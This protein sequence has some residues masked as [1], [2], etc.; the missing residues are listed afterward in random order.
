L[1]RISK[2]E[3]DPEYASKAGGS[4]PALMKSALQL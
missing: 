2:L 1:S 3:A 4:R